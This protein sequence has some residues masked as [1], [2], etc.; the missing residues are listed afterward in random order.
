MIQGTTSSAGKSVVTAGICR[1]FASRGLKVAPF[2]PQNM[3]LNS[4]VTVEG[5]EIGRSQAVQAMAAGLEPENDM[6]PILL[7]PNTDQGAQVIVNGQAIGNMEAVDYHAFKAEAVRSV[8]DAYNRLCEKYD[9]VIVEGAGSPAEVNLRHNDIAN[10]GFAT[11]AQCPVL[12]CA[13]IDRG[14]VFA[15][16]TGTLSCLEKNEVDLIKGFIINRFRGDKSLLTS[17][18]DWLTEQTG[19]PTLGVLPFLK[20]LHIEAEDSVEK[21]NI[22]G[23]TAQSPLKIVVP[24]ISRI[25]NH[26]DFDVLRLQSGVELI[27]VEAGQTIPP[28][29]LVVLPGS[30]NTISDLNWL[31]QHD[32]PSYINRHLRYGGK[33]IGICAGFQMIGKQIHDPSGL[34]G[35]AESRQGLG[36]MDF[37]T[38]LE[39]HKQLTRVEGRFFGFEG[40]RVR[41]YEIHMGKTT[42]PAL[43]HPAIQ[44]HEKVDG[45]I[46]GDGQILGTY[47]HGL[48]DHEEACKALLKWAGFKGEVVQDYDRLRQKAFDRVAAMLD[49]EIGFETLYEV[50]QSTV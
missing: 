2:K 1:L 9:V 18:L 6:N 28:A 41:G 16:L 47:L 10:M 20:G 49:E 38:V 48:F 12:L 36:L 3:A 21:E 17:G 19:K 7:K 40:A 27:Y 5:G 34:E 33:L 22:R 13:D 43:D 4:A 31:I 24:R 26:T 8:M 23:E 46:S 29:D 45:V 25:S 14:G 37:E 39:P 44:L 30:K 11:R 32:W 15:H 35:P 50:A 42:G